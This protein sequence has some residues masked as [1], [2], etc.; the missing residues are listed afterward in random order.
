MKIYL[1]TRFKRLLFLTG[2]TLGILYFLY[3]VRSILPPFIVAVIFAYLL[4]PL[5]EIW[6]RYRI[7]RT[8]AIILTY[9][10]V[11]AVILILSFYFFPKIVKELNTFA[12]AVPVYTKQVQDYLGNLY[13][14]YHRIII[15]E[16]IRQVIDETVRGIERQM[17]AGVRQVARSIVGIFAHAVSIILAP[18]LSFY[19]LKDL[20]TISKRF[21]A[22]LPVQWRSD[23]LYLLTEIDAVLTKFIRGHL[24]VAT[25]VG[26]LTALGL[27]ILKMEFA[28]L[29]G[30][31]AGI[32][33]LIP[34][35]GPVI[36]AVPA[37]ALALLKSKVL[38]L[39]V[40]VVMVVV[41]QLESNV[42]SP[43]ILGA[44]VGLHPLVVI[45]VLLAGG[46]LYG[47]WGML[48]AVPV[49]AVVRIVANHF[50]SRL[51]NIP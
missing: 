12:D 43:K 27:A 24:L 46:H 41:Q 47:V 1:S 45:F 3:L 50:F 21:I 44:S 5:V 37:V 25:I 2:L 6:E 33:D 16:S 51:I 8:W 48:A 23:I 20:D 19:L 30:I 14:G 35:F 40:V 9:L 7:P 32:A 36:G 18:V 26:A 17:I 39:Y 34:Y 10:K 4:H 42:I 38:A 29:L 13:R 22:L 11:I 31:V 49:A 15:P 28:L